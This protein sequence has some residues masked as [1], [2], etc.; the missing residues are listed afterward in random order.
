MFIEDEND[1]IDDSS[2]SPADSINIIIPRSTS[3]Q[4]T[5]DPNGSSETKD[6]KANVENGMGEEAAKGGLM[7]GKEETKQASTNRRET[8]KEL[9]IKNGDEDMEE[10][11]VC[12]EIQGNPL[13]ILKDPNDPYPK[14]GS[15]FQPVSTLVNGLDKASNT[16]DI[17]ICHYQ[18]PM[19]PPHFIQELGRCFSFWR[20]RPN[21]KPVLKVPRFQFHRFLVNNPEQF[22]EK[23]RFSQGILEGLKSGI[24]LLVVKDIDGPSV[25]T[26]QFLEVDHYVSPF[27]MSS[28][29]DAVAFRDIYVSNVKTTVLEES[30]SKDSLRIV[31]LNREKTRRLDNPERILTALKN[32]YPQHAVILKYFE[33][34]SFEEQVNFLSKADVVISPTG[35]QLTG[36]MFMEPCS[37]VLELFPNLY[38]TPYYFNSLATVFGLVH[39]N[40]YVSDGKLPTP[41]YLDLKTRLANTGNNICPSL[42]KIVSHVQ[43]MIQRRKECL[44]SN[45]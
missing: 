39:A 1:Y 24:D 2:K 17:A 36:M 7:T 30:K 44:A 8:I 31:I 25:S 14:T 42:D 21:Q 15:A 12:T 45:V 9:E 13:S 26:Q 16:S 28:R 37:A 5:S 38:Y 6:E 35:A 18:C 29:E 27:A 11:P 4:N 33:D 41:T 32:A 10:L 34:A 40:W 20:S 3:S 43:T 22:K 19:H 23:F